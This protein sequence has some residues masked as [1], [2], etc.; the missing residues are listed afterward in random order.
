[1]TILYIFEKKSE[2]AGSARAHAFI[3]RLTATGSTNI[4]GAVETALEEPNSAKTEAGI[5]LLLSDGETNT[6]F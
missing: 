2:A 3:R 4:N 5:I 1:M 6:V